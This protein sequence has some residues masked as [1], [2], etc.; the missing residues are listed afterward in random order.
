[1]PKIYSFMAKLHTRQKR[2]LNITSSK[3]SSKVLKKRKK[4]GPRTFKTEEAAKKYAAD[5]GIKDFTL[6]KVK[7][8]KRFQIVAKS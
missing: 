5:N 8:G 1:M 7:H 3:Q 4:K 6:K 2:Y